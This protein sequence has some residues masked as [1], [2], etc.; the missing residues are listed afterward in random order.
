LL[1]KNDSQ[2]FYDNMDKKIHKMIIW[3]H[4]QIFYSF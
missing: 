1:N 3:Y 4:A 2:L